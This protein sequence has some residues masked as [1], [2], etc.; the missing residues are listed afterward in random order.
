M[1]VTLTDTDRAAAERTAESLRRLIDTFGSLNLLKLIGDKGV[2]DL[3]VL[4]AVLMDAARGRT[5]QTSS[6][7]PPPLD[8]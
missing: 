6:S 1:T 3:E 4:Y 8:V 5:C 7:P 2:T